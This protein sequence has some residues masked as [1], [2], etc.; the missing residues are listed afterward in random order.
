MDSR[1]IACDVQADTGGCHACKGQSDG[2]ERV[3]GRWGDGVQGRV[4]CMADYMRQI[5]VTR[6]EWTNEEVE[7]EGDREVL[8]VGEGEEG[9]MSS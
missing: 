9:I 4:A 3:N 5:R 8:R 6:D 1:V 2:M 7:G